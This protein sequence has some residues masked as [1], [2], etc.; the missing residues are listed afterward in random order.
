MEQYSSVDEYVE[1][2]MKEAPHI[3]DKKD[4]LWHIV[5]I[6]N[7]A[8]TNVEVGQWFQASGSCLRYLSDSVYIADELKLLRQEKF[9]DSYLYSD[10]EIEANFDWCEFIDK[11]KANERWIMIR[12]HFDASLLFSLA[13]FIFLIVAALKYG[14]TMTQNNPWLLPGIVG[15][16]GIF[17]I[18]LNLNAIR[19]SKKKNKY[20]SGIPFIGGIHL[21]LAGLMSPIRWLA[22][23]FLLDYSI[24]SFVWALIKTS[25]SKME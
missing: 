16:I 6:T 9:V 10:S 21:L 20:V 24:W 14:M 12:R 1:S 25:P 17:W 19:I 15:A 7:K 5:I 2:R 18:V 13:I 11:A 8:Y 3:G 22:L 4:S 23:L